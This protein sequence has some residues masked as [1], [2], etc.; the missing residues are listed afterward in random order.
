VEAH[1]L[2]SFDH[3][4]IL[5]IRG[6]A[7]NGVA[8]FAQGC[9][10]DSFFLLL[11][12]LQ[13]SLD[14]RLVKW[15]ED[16]QKLHG[17]SSSSLMLSPESSPVRL[18]P[19]QDGFWSRWAATSLHPQQQHLHQE[20]QEQLQQEFI[21]EPRLFA[22]KIR[23]CQEISSALAYLHSRDVIY[24]DLKPNN[25]GFHKDGRVQLFDFGLSREL[26][27]AGNLTDPFVMSGKVCYLR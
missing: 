12:P 5:K 18:R 15:K 1:L 17:S 23:I 3:P 20:Q 10:H 2:A 26:P 11:D 14:Q 24:R 27:S 9:R 19:K 25:I 8:S 16:R 21:D 4:N 7:M 6:W 22:E 13:E